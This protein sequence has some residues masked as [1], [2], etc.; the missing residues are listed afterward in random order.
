LLIVK[1]ILGLSKKQM[2]CKCFKLILILHF[3]IMKNKF[4][5]I[6]PK[7]TLAIISTIMS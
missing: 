6:T 2:L 7:N 1:L 4:Q 3:I 5:K